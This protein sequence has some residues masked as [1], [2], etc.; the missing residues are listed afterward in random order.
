MRFDNFFEYFIF[1]YST[2]LITSYLIL[3]V[4]S[5]IT[6]I[7]YKNYNS[8]LDDETLYNSDIVPGISVV[9]PAYNEE[10]TIITNVHSLL[11]LDYPLFEVVIINDG[12][13]DSTLEKLIKEYDLV[14][15][16]YAY[17]E[18]IKTKRFKG[19]YKSNN[20]EYDKLTV[21]DKENGGTKADASN[22]GVNASVFP[23]FLCTDVDCILARNTLL[24]MIKPILIK[25]TKVI[26]VGAALRMVN[27]CDVEQGKL[28]RVRPPKNLIPRF[29]E[30]EYVR[31]YL[32][33]KMGWSFIN[34]VPNVSGGLGLFDKDVAIRSGG[35]DGKSHAEDM[36]LLTRMAVYMMNNKLKYRVEYIPLSC[37]WT[38][39]PPDINILSRQ[40]TRW[41]AGLLQLFIVHRRILFNPKYKRLGL[42]IFPYAFIFEFLAP[43]IELLG[44]ISIIYLLI[45]GNINWDTAILIF[46]YSYCFAIMISIM[47]VIWDNIT[48]KYYEKFSE[49]L[50]LVL[51]AF[52]EP[53]IYHPMIIFFGIKFISSKELSWG[54]MTR[55]GIASSETK[56]KKPN[57]AMKKIKHFVVFLVLAL[58]TLTLT[59]Q[60]KSS[61]SLFNIAKEWGQKKDNY[62][63]ALDFTK[64]ANKISPKDVDIQ[65]YLGKCYLE[66]GQYDKARYILRKAKDARLQNYTALIYLLNVEYET[67]RYSSAICYVNEMLEQTPYEKGLWIKK[68]N[69]YRDMG[70]EVEAMREMKR[71][72]QIFPN[73][74]HIQDN[75]IY[76]LSQQGKE[77]DG[78][79]G[80]K[81]IYEEIIKADT[82]NK[83]AY[84]MLIKNELE[85][86]GNPIAALS[87]TTRALQKMPGDTLLIRK[88]IGLLEET[89][90]YSRALDFLEE[91]KNYVSANEYNQLN[92]YLRNQ[93]ARFYENTDPYIINKKKYAQNPEN[94]Q[95]LNYI[96]ERH[97][98]KDTIPTQN[99][100]WIKHLKETLLPK[101]Y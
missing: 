77:E 70:N 34:A 99:I 101:I 88:K 30:L 56:E 90:N 66:L 98:P 100:I 23:Y 10:K 15:V 1:F 48:F 53:F 78:Y 17:V 68:M 4:F 33:S 63:K 60:K 94:Q 59:A 73:D 54:T 28:T 13:K 67:K 58:N 75:Y 12:S 41:A 40:R 86:N 76:M 32:L 46:L 37:C 5:M 14:K 50:S 52:L 87:Y 19:I 96:K 83:E 27:N 79:N 45:F 31:A 92:I 81:D 57:H 7:R 65:E 72:H 24:K 64:R 93:A 21:V 42:V 38:E 89:G 9:A 6:I 62:R 22:A 97:L 82:S 84:L 47:V 69:L 18:K 16:P 36:D 80:T 29:Q 20:P 44:V 43:I 49:V 95:A 25:K 26:A 51:V 85:Y 39:G 71:I 3:A 61:D 11:T 74:K 55:K 91:K 35:Y 2:A 8:N